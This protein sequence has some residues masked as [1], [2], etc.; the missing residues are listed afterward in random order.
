MKQ[1]V[2][3]WILDR[4]RVHVHRPADQAFS[5]RLLPRGMQDVVPCGQEALQRGDDWAVGMMD[6]LL[7]DLRLWQGKPEAALELAEK[8]R[9]RFKKLSDRF[10]TVQALAPLLRAQVVW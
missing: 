9:L 3:G 5:R 6:T 4:Q 8:A 1:L 7:A 10:G 2:E